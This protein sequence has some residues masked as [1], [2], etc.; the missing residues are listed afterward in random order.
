MPRCHRSIAAGILGTV[1]LLVW[2]QTPRAA[3]PSRADDSLWQQAGERIAEHRQAGVTVTVADSSGAPLREAE[4][5]LAQTRHA[6]LFGSNIFMWGRTGDEALETAY[7]QRYAGLLNYATLP[8]YW[9][10]YESQQ[11]QPQHERTRQIAAWCREQ[12]IVCKGHPLA[13][14]YADPRWLPDDS[15]QIFQLQLARIG[16]CVSRFSAEIGI[17][18]VVNEATHFDREEFKK[19]AP[20]MT[21]AWGDVGQIEFTKRC[22]VEARKANPQAVLL[23][24]DYRTDADYERVIEQLV[25]DQGRRLYDV[26]GIQSHMHGGAWSNARIWEVCERF[27]R[28]GV[29][30][31]F[32]ETTIVSGPRS[33][34]GGQWSTTPEGEARQADEV[35]RFYTML[36]SHPAVEG[37]TWWDFSD[38]HA[39]QNAPAGFLRKDMTA[40]P[41]YDKLHA[42]IKGDWWTDTTGSTDAH[43]AAR[44]R[45]TCGDY[46]V[47]VTAGGKTVFEGDLKVHRGDNAFDIS[48]P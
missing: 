23:I 4:I 47:T 6:F 40:K 44:F 34:G 16:D 11:G 29:P 15:Q 7:R 42:A 17:W 20:K 9:A 27:A 45:A 10:S 26:I 32:T 14:N 38:L 19:R 41:V 30:L 5:R 35:L 22:F 36:Y 46:R 31:H 33:E 48:L 24:N 43:G 39:W 3:E 13:W 1:I 2:T 12:G 18:D 37:L 21:K 28:F 25:D 8:F